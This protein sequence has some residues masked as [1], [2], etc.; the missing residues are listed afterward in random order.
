[1]TSC[2]WFE[3]LSVEL[4]S[5]ELH[6]RIKGWKSQPRLFVLCRKICSIVPQSHLI[7]V[8]LKRCIVV[9]LCQKCYCFV[10]TPPLRFVP[11]LVQ[12][13][14]NRKTLLK[15]PQQGERTR[16]SSLCS[17]R[18]QKLKAPALKPSFHMSGKSQ[19]IGDFAV[20]RPSQ[21]LPTYLKIARRLSQKVRLT[22]S[23]PNL[24]TC[25]LEDW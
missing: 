25:N 20:S 24:E 16:I 22:N 8:I 18:R 13:P 1:M 3:L 5:I 17:F 12:M 10:P 9:K 11:T 23:S 2:L 7:L 19:T 6:L 15:F 21:I 4:G 14:R